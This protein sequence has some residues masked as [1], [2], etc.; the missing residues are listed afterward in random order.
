MDLEKQT[1]KLEKM[2]EAIGDA[3][4]DKN[5]K[6]KLDRDEERLKVSLL[7]PNFCH[8]FFSRFASGKL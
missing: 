6:K 5:A 4:L 2:K 7:F 1:K 3:T 8:G